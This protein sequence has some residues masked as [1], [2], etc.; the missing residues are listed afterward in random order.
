MG[1]ELERLWLCDVGKSPN[2]WKISKRSVTKLKL[3]QW[4][5]VGNR[6]TLSEK[7]W[8]EYVSKKVHTA[9]RTFFKKMQK[10]KKQMPEEA[11][12]YCY[13]MVIKQLF[14][15]QQKKYE[16]QLKICKL[17][18]ST[19]NDSKQQD[20]LEMNINQ[21]YRFL[22]YPTLGKKGA[23]QIVSLLRGLPTTQIHE[24]DPAVTLLY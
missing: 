23:I 6:K 5:S 12:M 15:K 4:M 10:S 17:Q 19:I 11:K 9:K 18:L 16:S 20:H 24:T 2:L 3:F 1:S 7:Y 21:C 22:K 13:G 8:M 14:E